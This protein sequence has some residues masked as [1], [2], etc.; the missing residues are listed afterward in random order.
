MRLKVDFRHPVKGQNFRDSCEMTFSSILKPCHADADAED[1]DIDA[2]TLSVHHSRQELQ[3]SERT[4]VPRAVIL[5]SMFKAWES[6]ARLPL[7]LGRF[8]S[9]LTLS[10]LPFTAAEGEAGEC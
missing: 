10:A 5:G 4:I 9:W 2:D 7:F 1:A 3:T 6:P 8:S